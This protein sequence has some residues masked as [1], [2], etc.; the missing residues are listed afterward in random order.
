MEHSAVR[1]VRGG[2]LW[3]TVLCVWLGE[4]GCGAQCRA[5]G[6]RREAVEHSA[7]RVVRGG[8]LC[9][10]CGQR[11]KAVERGAVRVVRGGRLCRACG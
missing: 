10:V 7:V 3:S 5:C 4:G 8:R 11:R 6:Q 9:R 2:R 1:V